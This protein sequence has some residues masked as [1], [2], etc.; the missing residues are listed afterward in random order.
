MTEAAAVMPA[1]RGA[2]GV[3]AGNAPLPAGEIVSKGNEQTAKVVA[4]ST[5]SISEV[6]R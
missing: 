5:G 6:G 3:L 2:D 4:H 1:G